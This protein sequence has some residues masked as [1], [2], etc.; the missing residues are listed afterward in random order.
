MHESKVGVTKVAALVKNAENFQVYSVLL[1]K[2]VTIIK[3]VV[4]VMN[5]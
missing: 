3:Y 4:V 1:K 2:L 5:Y